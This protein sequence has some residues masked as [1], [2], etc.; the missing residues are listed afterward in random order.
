MNGGCPVFKGAGKTEMEV[1]L[2]DRI[3]GIQSE[4]NWKKQRLANHNAG[5]QWAEIALA[6]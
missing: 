5:M 6:R 1:G 3:E 2:W 4:L